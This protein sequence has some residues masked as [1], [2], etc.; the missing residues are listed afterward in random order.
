MRHNF[1]CL[2]LISTEFN[3]SCRAARIARRRSGQFN[4]ARWCRSRP[5]IGFQPNRHHPSFPDYSH[6]P[7]HPASS[8]ASTSTQLRAAKS[9]VPA[10]KALPWD[11][12]YRRVRSKS[13]KA[14]MVLSRSRGE[15]ADYFACD[16]RRGH[17]TTTL[18]WHPAGILPPRATAIRCDLN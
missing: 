7:A 12:P 10:Y 4:L 6:P 13:Q 8:P 5:S 16:Q 1:A 15:R 17:L 14:E 9:S 2:D 11:K 18:V 3:T